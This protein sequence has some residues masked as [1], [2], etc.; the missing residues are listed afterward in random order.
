MKGLIAYND[1]ESRLLLTSKV[2]N[3]NIR[4]AYLRIKAIRTVIFSE[5]FAYVLL[6]FIIIPPY[7]AFIYRLQNVLHS[8]RQKKLIEVNQK[9]KNHVSMRT[10][11]IIQW[12]QKQLSRGVL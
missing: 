8:F 7:Y 3:R 9:W 4:Y 2:S 10:K 12:L 11:W 5:N 6:F 1:P